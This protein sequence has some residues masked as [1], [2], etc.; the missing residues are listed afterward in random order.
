MFGSKKDRTKATAD[1]FYN[2]TKKQEEQKNLRGSLIKELGDKLTPTQIL[3]SSIDKLKQIKEENNNKTPDFPLNR[4]TSK[5]NHK[6]PTGGASGVEDLEKTTNN[7]QIPLPANSIQEKE[8]IKPTPN[9]QA[10]AQ[11]EKPKLLG[12]IPVENNEEL[13]VSAKFAPTDWD[14]EEKEENLESKEIAAVDI[15]N[16]TA[17]LQIDNSVFSDKAAKKA[18]I[19]IQGSEGFKNVAYKPTPTDKWTIGYGHT[20][21][22]QPGDKITEEEAERFFKEDFEQH[23][24]PLKEVKIPLSE[25]E[26]IALASFIYNVGPQAFLDSTLL[27]KLNANDREGATK[28]LKKWIYENKKVNQGLINRRNKEI[29]LFLTPDE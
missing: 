16:D 11:E 2:T 22:V 13:V 20:K 1:E 24:K 15:K 26:K 28:E 3:Y 4:L 29:N 27:K 5:E 17:D 14:K 25:N 12:K 6:T 18:R 7:P 9:P 19:F 23:I 10:G 8:D 21:N